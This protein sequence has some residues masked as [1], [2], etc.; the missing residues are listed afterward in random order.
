MPKS[1]VS[2]VSE[3]PKVKKRAPSEYNLFVSKKMK[4][5]EGETQKAKMIK[6]AALWQKQNMTKKIKA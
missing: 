6:I 1:Q 5:V 3:E 4:E 2:K